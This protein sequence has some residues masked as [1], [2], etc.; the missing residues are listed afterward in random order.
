MSLSRNQSLPHHVQNQKREFLGGVYDLTFDYDFARVPRDTGETQMRIDFSN[1]EG[2]WDSVVNEAGERKKKRSLAELSG[3]HKRWLEEEW[4]D[5]L[6]NG[7]LSRAELHKRWFGSDIVE[8]LKKLV[9]VAGNAPTFSHSID[10]K[11]T[12]VIVDEKFSCPI[13]PATL[14]ATLHAEAQAHIKVDTSFGLTIITTM[15][16]PPDLSNSYLYLK[17]KGE[18]TATFTLDAIASLSYSSGNRE[19]FGL[20]NFPGA[21]FHV[22]GILTVGPNFRLLGSLE[23]SV[24]LAVHLKSQVNIG[25]WSVQQTYPQTEP[26]FQPQNLQDPKRDGTQILGQPNVSHSV[27]ASGEI[28]THLLPTITFGIDFEPR[29]KV[30]SCKV[31][32]VADGWVRFHATAQV[33]SSN[34]DCPFRYGV[35]AGADLYAE[36]SVPK[37]FGWGSGSRFDIGHVSPKQIVAGGSCPKSEKRSTDSANAHIDSHELLPAPY[38]GQIQVR[39]RR[40]QCILFHSNF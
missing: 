20:E 25:S 40:F 24:V 12:A 16:F 34:E 10:E 18:V 36:L 2:Y 33:S 23:A 6:H 11:I 37:L 21:T 1:M 31:D 13:G 5:D 17:N 27:S 7:G 35:D 26:G 9:G 22:P 38:G 29:W 28:V 19:L 15:T 14:Q 8:W 39:T 4:R 3:N 30:D 32:L